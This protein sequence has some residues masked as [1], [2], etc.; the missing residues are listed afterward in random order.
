MCGAEDER[1]E[2]IATP[3]HQSTVTVTFI[4]PLGSCVLQQQQ[5]QQQK[6]R[7][8]SGKIS[9][10]EIISIKLIA[11]RQTHACA[12]YKASHFGVEKFILL[13]FFLSCNR[14]HKA[15][16]TYRR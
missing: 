10:W 14:D 5:Q 6:R 2:I 7:H 12:A 8:Q 11:K 15:A 1:L 16:T 3:V 13:H 9:R 4:G